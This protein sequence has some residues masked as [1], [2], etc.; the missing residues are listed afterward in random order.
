MGGNAFGTILEASSFPRLPPAVYAALKS[1][2]LPKMQSLYSFVAIPIEAPEKSDYGDLDFVVACPK[3]ELIPSPE[4]INVPPQVVQQTIDARF[5]NPMDGNRTSNFAV[6]IAQGEWSP[7][8]HRQDEIDK[9]RDAAGGEILYQ[10]RVRKD[11]PQCHN[12]LQIGRC[13]CLYG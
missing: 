12:N 10:V 4:V 6:P 11:I 5:S 7:L 9:R 3:I 13:Q 2:L 8:G 1:R